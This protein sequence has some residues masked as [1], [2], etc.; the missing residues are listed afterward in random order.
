ML[1]YRNPRDEIATLI[2]N[3]V[4]FEDWESVWVQRRWADS[5]T[6]FRFTAAERDPI[7][8]KQGFPLWQK[9]QF[10]PG[11]LCTVLMAD[12]LAVTGFIETRQVAYDADQHGVQLD[13]KSRSELA[14]KSSVDSETGSW[15]NQNFMQIASNVAG[16]YGVGVIPVGSPD[17]SPF[18][19]CQNEKGELVWDF[20]ERLARQKG[21]V[22]GS[23]HLG[24]FL[25]IGPHSFP[26]IDRLIEG[27]NIKSCQ[28]VISH[29]DIHLD[30]DVSAQLKPTDQVNGSAANEV[31]AQVSSAVQNVLYSKIIIPME[32]PPAD[33][34]EVF[35]RANYERM[36]KDGSLINAT[37][38]VQGW[39]R[40]GR[41]LWNAGDQ[42]HVY[43]PMAMLDQPMAIQNCTFSQD[44]RQG[45]ITTLDLVNPEALQGSTN[46]DVSHGQTQTEN[47]T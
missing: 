29:K 2:V 30:V 15:D 23:D 6:L 25:A 39:L 12:Q 34:G 20:L 26:V 46:V 35:K 18:V 45:T 5:C 41:A 13:G 24:N 38:V 1:Q 40:A 11:D 4:R 28:C 14:A 36:W 17:S 22:L 3:G 7:F 47:P 19:Q 9:L 8:T 10:K 27:Y 37:I 42:V 31:T 21:I 33:Q 44:N 32:T 43:S 16:K